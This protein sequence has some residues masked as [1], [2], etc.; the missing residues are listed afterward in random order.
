MPPEDADIGRRPCEDTGR[1]W[2]GAAASQGASGMTGHQQKLGR[3]RKD[4][5]TDFGGS[6]ALP[7][8]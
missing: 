1:D 2:S 8:S 5:S 3:A 7:T 4:S 6:K